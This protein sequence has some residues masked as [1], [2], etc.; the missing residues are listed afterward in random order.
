MSS[1]CGDYFLKVIN[2]GGE[3]VDGV[4]KGT[5]L[6]DCDRKVIDGGL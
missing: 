3:G 1:G 4:N 6:R 5:E 2:C